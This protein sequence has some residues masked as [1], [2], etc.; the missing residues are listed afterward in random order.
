MGE[1]GGGGP[2]VAIKAIIIGP[3]KSPT[4]TYTHTPGDVLRPNSL[5]S[6]RSFN[7]FFNS[8]L[9]ANQGQPAEILLANKC[10]VMWMHN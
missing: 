4:T 2:I 5:F 3:L 10:R 9:L 8:T 6:S 7:L 1:R